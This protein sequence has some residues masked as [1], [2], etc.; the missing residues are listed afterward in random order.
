MRLVRRKYQNEEDYWRIRAFLHRVFMR[1]ERR[2][3]CW[4]VYRWD[5]WRWHTNAAVWRFSLEAAV[6]LWETGDG[7][8]AAVLHPDGPG[9]ALLHVHPDF[10]SA[11][12]EVEMMNT[13]E[14]HFAVSR[15]DGQRLAIWAHQC[16]ALRQDLLARRG[17]S[18]GPHPE[19]QLRRSMDQP[20]PDFQPLA[21]YTVRALEDDELPARSWLAWK[22]LHPDQPDE[23][24]A[25]WE[26][27]RCVQAAPLY[28]RDLDLVIA[29]PDGELTAFCTVW[30]DD[31][32]GTASFEPV[33]VHP[34]HRGQGLGKAIVAEGLRRAARLG[35]T[36][37]TAVSPAG[38]AEGLHAALGFAGHELSEPW[39]KTW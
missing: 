6:F 10:R 25:G 3:V 30:F 28:R 39:V 27:Y 4:P 36:L 7:E 32:A 9:E 13:A 1:Y 11:D 5:Y 2:A 26:W 17:F 33:G 34:A 24:Y 8:V 23:R 20:A 16:D 35:A 15:Q 18:R 22:T 37:C 19:W 14:T 21:G 31:A 29:A 12:L 38:Q